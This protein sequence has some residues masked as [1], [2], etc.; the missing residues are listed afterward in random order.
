M[1][2]EEKLKEIA[3]KYL[4]DMT[5]VMGDMTE[6]D[7]KIDLGYAPFMLVV[8]P[9]VGTLRYVRGRFREGVRA[10]VGFFDLV[11]RDANADD[12]FAA[13]RRMV[14]KAKDFLRAYN[15]DGYFAPVDGIINTNIITERMASALSGLFLDMEITEA[16]GRC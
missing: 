11:D 12:N 1:N 3:E 9:E 13:Y 16:V 15:A 6:I 5:L 2:I 7:A 4:P 10:L 8:F 14:E